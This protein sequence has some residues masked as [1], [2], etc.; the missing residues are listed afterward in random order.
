MQIR[1]FF[2]PSKSL[3][4]DHFRS[5]RSKSGG[6]STVFSTGVENFGERPNTHGHGECGC[7]D[8]TQ[9]S[10]DRRTQTVAHNS[11]RGTRPTNAASIDTLRTPSLTLAVL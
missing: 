5:R 3:S 6:F 8:V 4:T 9:E 10:W 11:V 7:D 1:Q 2:A